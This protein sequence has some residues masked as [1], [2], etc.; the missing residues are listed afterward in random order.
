M[1]NGPRIRLEPPAEGAYSPPSSKASPLRT[2]KSSRRDED[3]VRHRR[4][5]LAEAATIEFGKNGF[6][7]TTVEQ[8]ARRAGMDKRTLYDYVENKRD[9]LYLVMTNYLPSLL[10]GVRAQRKGHEDP[11]DQLIAMLEWHFEELS[12][13]SRLPLLFYRDLRSLNRPDMEALLKIVDEL[14]EEYHQVLRRCIAKKIIPRRDP[15]LLA[16]STLVLL[17][18]VGVHRRGLRDVEKKKVFDHIVA[19]TTSRDVT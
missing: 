18:M 8:V 5:L 19:L 17:D 10:S 13:K 15:Y 3:T 14:I 16:H 9:L 6:E 11:W 4:A 2:I 7:A 12:G 1:T